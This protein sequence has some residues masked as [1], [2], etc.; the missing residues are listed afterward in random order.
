MTDVVWASLITAVGML[1]TSITAA[2]VQHRSDRL[3]SESQ[4]K[5][6]LSRI[7]HESADRRAE[8]RY[9]KIVD[10]LADLL[11]VIDPDISHTIDRESFTR[12]IVG[13]QMLLDP[14]VQVEGVLNGVLTKMGLSCATGNFEARLQGS[15][16]LIRACQRFV[17]VH[18][19]T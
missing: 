3:S 18:N 5:R 19:R 17:A 2:I 4:T 8:L 15:D 11:V 12:L 1:A 16:E 14:N 7:K 6:E 13:T 9:N 10:Q